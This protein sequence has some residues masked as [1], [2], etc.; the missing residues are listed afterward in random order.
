VA[1]NPEKQK[2]KSSSSLVTGNLWRAI[3]VMSW[4]LLLTTIANSLVGLVD[5]KVAS[6]LGSDTQA[7]VGL[8][9]HIIFIFMVFILSVGVGS[10][11]LVS[12]AYGAQ[13]HHEM[14]K[15]TSQSFTL[16]ILLGLVMT[17]TASLTAQFVLGYFTSSPHV[18]SEG[19][20]YLMAYSF[21]LMPYSISIIANA[22]FR[23]IGDSK[24]PLCIISSM[25]LVNIVGDYLTVLKNFPVP[26]LGV[27]GMAYASLAAS[28]LGATLAIFFMRRSILKESLGQLLPIDKHELMRIARIGIP[29][30]FQRMGWAL[31][32]FAIFFILARC[33]D[34][35]SALAS[36]TIGMRVES[37]IFMPLLA[38]SLAV[39][40]I[41]GQNLGANETERAFQAGWR[42][43]SIGIYMMVIAGFVLYS[44]AAPVAE[45]MSNEPGTVAYTCQYLK[46][47]ALGEPCLAV[48]MVLTGALQGAGDTKAPMWFTIITNWLI[49]IPLAYVLAIIFKL[50]PSGVWWAMLSSIV[51][52][53]MLVGWRYQSRAWLRLKI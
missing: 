44:L 30:A 53:G 49:R 1:G 5:V 35:V 6:Y 31:S 20:A 21:V 22:V 36:W 17:A 33:N 4:P 19:R 29:S 46:I 28:L 9:E 11:A 34:S 48:G 41:V 38:L 8:A 12:R 13:D 24:T 51:I 50:G 39:A 45:L 26:G 10:T 15:A 2:E 40:S 52:Q 37:L 16:S 14:L 25:T 32:V 23:A 18:L 7:A 42:V 47:N 3:W 43:T 27:R